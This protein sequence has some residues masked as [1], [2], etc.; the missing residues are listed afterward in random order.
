MTAT[1]SRAPRRFRS[2]RTP[3]SRNVR[4]SFAKWYCVGTTLRSYSE[5]LAS[6]MATVST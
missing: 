2:V 5:Q 6:E 4:G 3:N 1:D